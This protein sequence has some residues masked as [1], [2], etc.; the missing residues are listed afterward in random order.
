VIGCYW[1]GATL[2]LLPLPR[3]WR[4]AAGGGSA[5]D[6]RR[7]TIVLVL[8]TA[9][10]FVNPYGLRGVLFPLE[11]LP[12]VTGSSLFSA[13]IGEFRP[14][15]QSGY[16]LPLAYLWAATIVTAALSFVLNV[17]RLHLGRLFATA[18]FAVL[19][20]QALRNVALFAWIAVPAIAGN[21]G[22]LLARPARTAAP[23]RGTRRRGE[24]GQ[25]ARP[26]RAGM[27]AAVGTG[28][29]VVAL[30]LVVAS[31][32]TNR[33]SYALGIER[34]FGL[35]VSALHFPIGAE[36]FARDVGIGGRPFNCLATGGYLAW[37]R[38]PEERVFVDGRLEVYPESFFRF[39]FDAIDDPG[40]W[41]AVAARYAPDYAL[42]YHVWGN[43][44][45]LARYLSAGHGW[46]LV[47]YDETA[48]LYLP[49]DDAH[50]EVRERAE[51]EFATRRAQLRAPMPPTGIWS[52]VSVPVA[53]FR[54]E[55]AYG[56]FLMKLGHVDQAI[57]AYQRALTLD[58][59][60][61]ATRFALGVSY[62]ASNRVGEA[63]VEWREVLRRDPS[64]ERARAALDEIDR[65]APR[66]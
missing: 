25:S 33:F 27:L 13:R 15:F 28:A 8:A 14:P 2:A 42:L 19:S 22:A 52:G 30:A 65:P 35:G 49:T 23:G 60:A 5:A 16:G 43:R 26:R 38:Y 3:A 31:V 7:L 47:Y 11:L 24:A 6:W 40:R 18:A 46:E 29:V 1:A 64:F 45:P 41:P 63:A 32:L 56:D 66:R 55:S 51:R 48:S 59:S 12:R 17:R 50:R 36:Q 37:R 20:T 44:H 34:E 58:P 61:S 21:L 10:C 4:E 62:W 54:R 53:A 39:Y 57:D 9:V